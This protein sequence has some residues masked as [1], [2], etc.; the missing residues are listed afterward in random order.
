QVVVLFFFQAED[1]IRDSSVTE[2]R[3]VLFRSDLESCLRQVL[4]QRQ[5]RP[6]HAQEHVV[7]G[8]QQRREAEREAQLTVAVLRCQQRL[9]Q[10]RSEE[11]RVGKEGSTGGRAAPERDKTHTREG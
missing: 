9:P 3:R 11:R 7:A 5:R 6:P 4:V 1:G 2:F 8:Q 10:P